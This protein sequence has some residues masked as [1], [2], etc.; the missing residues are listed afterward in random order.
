[1]K[2]GEFQDKIGVGAGSY[3]RF[4]SQNGPQKGIESDTFWA[5]A[6][7]FKKRQVAG[8]PVVPRKKKVKKEDDSA[9]TANSKNASGG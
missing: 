5:A 3:S 6:E 1:M 4:M 8:L 9:A 7:F 2:V